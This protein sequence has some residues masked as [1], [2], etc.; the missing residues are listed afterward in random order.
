MCCDSEQRCYVKSGFKNC[1]EK[2]RETE[3]EREEGRGK[4]RSVTKI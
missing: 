2:E 4:E 1:L 3:G